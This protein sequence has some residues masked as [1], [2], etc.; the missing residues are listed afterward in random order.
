M[1]NMKI[2]SVVLQIKM[3]RQVL[4]LLALVAVAIASPV[5]ERQNRIVGGSVA[6]LG[7][8]PYQVSLRVTA[9]NRHLCGGS[10][11]NSRWTLHAAHC[12]FHFSS[13]ND[14]HVI[15][16]SISVSSGGVAHTI[17][18]IVNHP[19]F[20]TRTVANDISISQTTSVIVFNANVQPIALGSAQTGGGVN[21]VVIGWGRLAHNGPLPDKLQYLETTTLT[22]ADCKSRFG[23]TNVPP[24]FDHKICTLTRVG[25][26]TCNMDS[27]GPL[28][29]DGAIIGIV[30]W[31]L[32]CAGGT[33]D[34]YDRVSY[35]RTWILNTIA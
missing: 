25:E 10:I 15:V 31:G 30:S 24:I 17:T 12:T 13:P 5:S 23:N 3:N 34:V 2:S 32:E 29:S 35:H 4:I 14:L 21:S 28:A 7:Q 20:S 9:E 27:G 26:G 33:P 18:K 1:K 8:F 11:I 22:N 6:S 16:G 19:N